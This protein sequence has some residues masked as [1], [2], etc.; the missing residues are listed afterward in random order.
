MVTLKSSGY[1]HAISLGLKEGINPDDDFF[2][3]LP[4]EARTVL[5]KGAAGKLKK[6]N[7]KP[8]FLKTGN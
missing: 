2:D 3:M 6:E 1:S 8:F 5:I 7:I 4:G